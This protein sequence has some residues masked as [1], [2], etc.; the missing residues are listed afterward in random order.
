M[1][2][3]RTLTGRPLLVTAAG[4]AMTVGCK[5]PEVIQPPGNLMA[6]PRITGEVC[7]ETVPAD[8]T[9]TVNGTALL[10]PQHCAPVAE[11][12]EGS[13]VA[14]HVEAPGYVP[15]DQ[16]VY[17]APKMTLSVTLAPDAPVIAPP[18]NLMPPPELPPQP[19]GNLIAPPPIDP[20]KNP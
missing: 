17:L 3:R 12:Y 11:N 5:D 4:V 2:R 9:I 6:P 14:V 8:A 1:A 20:P 10:P 16:T 19:V 7:V 13:A 15:Q 18:G